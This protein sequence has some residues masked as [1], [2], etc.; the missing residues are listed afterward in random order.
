MESSEDKLYN[1]DEK[2]Q[3]NNIN[4]IIE[5][6]NPFDA[7]EMLDKK[8]IDGLPGLEEFQEEEKL[9]KK[10]NN[11]FDMEEDEEEKEKKV[12]KKLKTIPVKKPKKKAKKQEISLEE[13][14]QTACTDYY[15]VKKTA[16]EYKEKKPFTEQFSPLSWNQKVKRKKKA[17][18]KKTWSIAVKRF[19]KTYGKE[20]ERDKAD[21]L[22]EEIQEQNQGKMLQF[23]GVTLDQFRF[24][25]DAEFAGN[26]A[27]NYALIRN[28]DSMEDVLKRYGEGDANVLKEYPNLDV[29]SLAQQAALLKEVK[30][31][32]DARRELMAHPYYVLLSSNEVAEYDLIADG[33]KDAK[34]LSFTD[35]NGKVVRRG[36]RLKNAQA[37][38]DKMIRYQQLYQKEQNC[39][40]KRRSSREQKEIYHTQFKSSMDTMGNINASKLKT[41][42]ED[43]LQRR[44]LEEQRRQEEERERKE[45]EDTIARWKQKVKD[46]ISKKSKDLSTEKREEILNEENARKKIEAFDKLDLSKELKA[47]SVDEILDNMDKNEELFQLAEETQE[48]ITQGAMLEH[49][50]LADDDIIR[51]R[52]KFAVLRK[53]KKNQTAILEQLTHGNDQL[54]KTKVKAPDWALQNK[55]VILNPNVDVEGEIRRLTEEHDKVLPQKMK[56][57]WKVL[58]PNK[59]INEDELGWLKIKFQIHSLFWDS[60]RDTK[61]KLDLEDRN[62]KLVIEQWCQEKN[63]SDEE[64]ARVL[65]D[66]TL[67]TWLEGK[68][69]TA[70]KEAMA[71][72]CG[73]D[74]DRAALKQT[75]GQD[76]VRSIAENGRYFNI[77]V[78]NPGQFISGLTSKLKTVRMAEND[79]DREEPAN[80]ER[81]AAMNFAGEILIPR[82]NTLLGMTDPSVM[83]SIVTMDFDEIRNLK[84]SRVA[85]KKNIEA[86]KDG[87]KETVKKIFDGFDKMQIHK[88][89]VID[90]KLTVKEELLL[91]TDL[92]ELYQSYRKSAG[93]DTGDFEQQQKERQV[94]IQSIESMGTNPAYVETEKILELRRTCISNL[95]KVGVQIQENR[96]YDLSTEALKRLTLRCLREGWNALEL[97]KKLNAFTEAGAKEEERKEPEEFSYKEKDA[98]NMLAELTEEKRD[99]KSMLKILSAHPELLSDLAHEREKNAMALLDRSF[100]LDEMK[101]QHEKDLAA[102]E[103]SKKE[104]EKKNEAVPKEL[105]EAIEKKEAELRSCTE[106]I[107]RVED[108]YEKFRAKKDPDRIRY[109]ELQKKVTEHRKRYEELQKKISVT[110][111]MPEDLSEEK[112]K[113]WMNSKAKALNEEEKKEFDELEKE[114]QEAAKLRYSISR[115]NQKK[116]EGEAELK[117]AFTLAKNKLTGP[118]A[119]L[120]SG[121]GDAMNKIA[122]VLLIRLKGEIPTA[123]KI[124]ELLDA[125]DPELMSVIKEQNAK[126]EDKVSK[127][128]DSV[129]EVVKKST[130]TIYD[131]GVDDPDII[132]LDAEDEKWE[133]YYK[134]HEHETTLE[135]RLNAKWNDKYG[136]GRF[137]SVVLQNYFQKADDK[138]KRKMMGSILRHQKPAEKNVAAGSAFANELSRAG[139]YI[140]GMVKGGGPLLQKLMQSVPEQLLTKELKSMVEDVKSNLDPIP[141]THVKKQLKEMAKA[142]GIKDMELSIVTSLGAASVGQTFLCNVKGE[143]IKEGT[144]V[145]VKILRPNLTSQIKEEQKTMLFCADE[146]NMHDGGAMRETYEGMLSKIDEEL[147]L[148]IEA[149]NCEKGKVYNVEEG[150]QKVVS[151]GVF[152]TIPTSKEY[153]LLEKA[154]GQTL[155]KLIRD[156]RAA[157]KKQLISAGCIV[158]D[159]KGNEIS[160]NRLNSKNLESSKAARMNLVK[161]LK[162]TKKKYK[163]LVKMGEKWAQE[164]LFGKQGFFHGD[165]HAGNIMVSADK[166][167]VLDF[168]NASEM[169]DEE[170]SQKTMKLLSI[171]AQFNQSGDFLNWFKDILPEKSASR[172]KLED[173]TTSL[174][175]RKEILD[176]FEACGKATGE[177]I[178][179]AIMALQKYG[180]EIPQKIFYFSQSELRLQNSIRDVVNEIASIKKAIEDIDRLSVEATEQ[181][182]DA[183]LLTQASAK[184]SQG[185]IEDAYKNVISAMSTISKE[186]FIKGLNEKDD[187]KFNEFRQK[188]LSP[189]DD[190]ALL[191]S[192]QK[193]KDDYYE[194][195][196]EAEYRG[197]EDELE[198]LKEDYRIEP[199]VADT[200]VLRKEYRQLM[201]DLDNAGWTEDEK[202][203]Q[204]NDWINKVWNIFMGKGALSAFGTDK[205]M[206]TTVSN[207][208]D[209]HDESQMEYVFNAFDMLKDMTVVSQN[210]DQLKNLKKKQAA[211]KDPKEQ[212]RIQQ[213]IDALAEIIYS[214]YARVQEVITDNNSTM[215]LVRNALNKGLNRTMP[216]SA[217]DIDLSIGGINDKI[218]LGLMD[219]IDRTKFD[220]TYAKFG[221]LYEKSKA[222]EGLTPKEQKEFDE[223]TGQMRKETQRVLVLFEYRAYEPNFT[224]QLSPWFS[225]PEGGAEL[226]RLYDEF[227]SLQK[228]YV[229]KVID[230]GEEDEQL[231]SSMRY[232][233]KL[234]LRQYKPMA[235]R[236][237]KDRAEMFEEKPEQVTDLKDFMMVMSDV[238]EDNS[239]N[240]I[241]IMLFNG[242]GKYKSLANKNNPTDREEL[243][244]AQKEDLKERMDKNAGEL[245]ALSKVK[246]PRKKEKLEH[247]K[248]M[249]SLEA[250]RLELEEKISK[251]GS[252][253]KRLQY[254]AD[255]RMLRLEEIATEKKALGND[256]E[257]DYRREVLSEEVRDILSKEDMVEKMKEIP[258]NREKEWNLDKL[259]EAEDKDRE[260]FETELQ[261][262]RVQ[263]IDAEI[264]ELKIKDI[265]GADVPAREIRK[266]EKNRNEIIEENKN[267]II[268]ENKNQIIEEK[269]VIHEAP[270]AR[271]QKIKELTDEKAKLE[272]T[273]SDKKKKKE[274]DKKKK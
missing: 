210:M 143:G 182:S 87:E 202:M 94:Q 89:E 61:E 166:A 161:L 149:E 141:L 37:A 153:M 244:K 181:W 228:K 264:R 192:G 234:F 162:D 219:G 113:E 240:I 218:K 68:S 249:L 128:Y 99:E 245:Q 142:S 80:K 46:V 120:M 90:S 54:E 262:I 23:M 190:A 233:E 124:A 196:D 251:A 134:Y 203:R 206:M 109:K 64:K 16:Y 273:L 17:E 32:M 50:G 253:D 8:Y 185:E 187:K 47:S 179:L 84:E 5:E 261:K 42:R 268:E 147:N 255:M 151:V 27:H 150:D 101:A 274:E 173:K 186:D 31:W 226:K 156:V 259:K 78:E 247:E 19:N 86:N 160:K 1:R 241:K 9:K 188:Y 209:K 243:Q 110:D 225:D 67:I 236:R 212:K 122:D 53:A 213:E 232:A 34:L 123:K 220:E 10:S 75:I 127:C 184:D 145:V 224:K 21:M 76:T 106:E 116:Y 60:I 29:K 267:E 93:V 168:G 137:V 121:L 111:G 133:D 180:I 6:E 170:Q 18:Q 171:A 58:N 73:T 125:K 52:A 230:K 189:F 239:G 175:I 155:D 59:K 66:K 238:V 174:K 41:T 208:V 30:E 13:E 100:V 91:H 163:H 20:K 114:R 205:V 227:R 26:L 14:I 45:K 221:P 57:L 69:A 118:E 79:M 40:F 108:R 139:Q 83:P 257:S 237:I 63:I 197:N 177:K 263:E 7:K 38:F 25:T 195:V 169:N 272:K 183:V 28:L 135:D 24:S 3:L 72:A 193:L 44:T 129:Q 95:R 191:Q 265:L 62:T 200:A 246:D 71:K 271:K 144:Q 217:Y 11:L 223:V 159:E 178:Y 15:F 211:S 256:P 222:K 167:T 132:P 216:G 165:M 152:N 4:N 104:Y 12:V 102:L 201:N 82:M 92:N 252:Y 270:A 105:S 250:R 176:T 172:K 81:S 35:P 148:T 231:E 258:R 260:N 36:Q 33:L 154:E 65:G 115:K 164:G 130:T 146:K 88:T 229:D 48:L 131:H 248:E 204:K 198:T 49:L 2:L 112:K 56:D 74:E 269:N 242:I 107:A 199:I 194:D 39:K 136:E 85:Y 140:S 158:V 77:S 55:L 98:V 117:D 235:L 214:D 97:E 96:Y 43:I 138:A 215:N 70:I 103:K 157:K 22:P 119:L 207:A 51:F 266:E 126:L 254:E